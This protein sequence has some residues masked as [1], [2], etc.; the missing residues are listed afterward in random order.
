VD[1]WFKDSGIVQFYCGLQKFYD[2]LCSLMISFAILTMYFFIVLWQSW[3]TLLICYTFSIFYSNDESG[4]SAGGGQ[5]SLGYLFGDCEPV[6]SAVKA[7]CWE[8]NNYLWSCW[9]T[10]NY[11]WSDS[12]NTAN[13][14]T[15][16]LLF[17]VTN[18]NLA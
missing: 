9:E 7:T 2:S 10:N 11:L 12:R 5:S 1:A 17:L 6:I 4:R 3:W 14:I 15:V 13:S 16:C 8:T 18:M